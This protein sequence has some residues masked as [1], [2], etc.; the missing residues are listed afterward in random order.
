MTAM[1][2]HSLEPPP[3]NPEEK[4]KMKA[5]EVAIR[6]P[7]TLG[8][9]LSKKET[10]ISSHCTPLQSSQLLG[11]MGFPRHTENWMKLALDSA[12]ILH[13]RGHTSGWDDNSTRLCPPDL[14]P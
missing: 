14:L 9:S 8:I 1:M 13:L 11:H 4:E 2:S 5:A 12:L 10:G 7:Q 6:A 3:V